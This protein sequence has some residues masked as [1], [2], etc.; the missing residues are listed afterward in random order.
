[1]NNTTNALVGIVSI[2]VG[3]ATISV[4]VSEKSNFAG[5]LTAGGDAFSKVLSAATNPFSRG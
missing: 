1:M 5:V 3:L 2:I 4:L